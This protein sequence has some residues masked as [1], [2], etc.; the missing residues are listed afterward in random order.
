MMA[1][2]TDVL[3]QAPGH[4]ERVLRGE[5]G[6][7]AAVEPDAMAAGLARSVD[8]VVRLGRGRDGLSHAISLEDANGQP[9]FVHDDGVFHRRTAAPAF[10][11]ILQAK[12]YGE[13]LARIFR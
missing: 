4:G 5:R 6:T 10:A 8:L 13:A 12:G 11:S 2:R 3:L 9:V 1:T 7:L